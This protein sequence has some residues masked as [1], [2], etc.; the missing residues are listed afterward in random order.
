MHILALDFD[1][2]LCDSSREVFVVAVDTYA[3]M[4]SGSLLPARLQPL[5][6]DALGGGEGF[7]SERLYE[8]FI[9][10]LALGNRAEDFGVSLTAMDRG[11]PIDGQDA[12][13]EYFGGLDPEWLA[14]FHTRFYEV[15]TKLRNADARAWIGLHKPYPGLA[16]LLRKHSDRTL[17]AV[18]TAKDG[19]SAR[20]LLDAMGYDGI[21]D[22]QLIFDKETGV[23]KTHHLEA[24]QQRTGIGFSKVTFIDDKLNHLVAVSRLGVRAV[25]AGWGFN[26]LREHALADRLG[27]D[28]A[29]LRSAEN[30]L[31][32]GE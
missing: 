25:L 29:T 14:R 6:D 13:D 11:A 9:G 16:D 28:V 1:G 15:R 2:V 30:V 3:S 27:F 4:E 21:F 8:I 19:V 32:K 20:L 26:T 5:R 24:L 12:Y 17:P 7:R 23:E 10:L 31:F 18:V 22:P